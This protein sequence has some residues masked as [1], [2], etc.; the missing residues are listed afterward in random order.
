M[1]FMR[2]GIGAT[3]IPNDVCDLPEVSLWSRFDFVRMGIDTHGRCDKAEQRAVIHALPIVCG[4][5]YW[6]SR[7]VGHHLLSL[8]RA[9]AVH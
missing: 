6:L 3:S 4:W 7:C 9:L 2:F 1:R 5:L 8:S